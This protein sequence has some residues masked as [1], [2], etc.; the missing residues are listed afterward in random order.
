MNTQET[1]LRRD[2]SDVEEAAKD[3]GSTELGG[4]EDSDTEDFLQS[5]A[6]GFTLEALEQ[7]ERAKHRRGTKECSAIFG[8]NRT[9]L[10]VT[11]GDSLYEAKQGYHYDQLQWAMKDEVKALQDNETCNLVRPPTD[12]D[13]IP[14]KGVYKVKL[15]PSVRIDKY[16]A[17]YVANAS[18]N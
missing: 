9:H 18:K 8:E 1:T 17:R 11:E 14:V 2:V 3:E 13:V 5:E 12:R 10:H 6:V 15:G 4:L 16:R 7:A